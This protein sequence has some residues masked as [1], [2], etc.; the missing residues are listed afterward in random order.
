[1][2]CLGLFMV[3]SRLVSS[4]DN[5]SFLMCYSKR[6]ST[7]QNKTQHT[8]SLISCESWIVWSIPYIETYCIL[9]TCMDKTY[10]SS[11]I[12]ELKFVYVIFEK[13]KTI[14][15]SSHT[16]SHHFSPITCMITDCSKL[17]RFE[18]INLSSLYLQSVMYIYAYIYAIH[19]W[20]Y[21]IISRKVSQ[22]WSEKVEK[23]N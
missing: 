13:K 19:F 22:S 11:Y 23:T 3:S 1:M 6:W 21:R 4:R 2:C 15:Q 10:L 20:S 17:Q 5:I 14:I 7:H 16:I 12:M 8:E 9:I 18:N